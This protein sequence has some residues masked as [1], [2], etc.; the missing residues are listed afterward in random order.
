MM[1]RWFAFIPLIVF[2][3]MAA[4]FGLGLREDPSQIPSQLINEPLPAFDL[5]P[6]E[7][8]AAGLSNA[9]LAGHVS[10]LNVFGS[11]CPPCEVEHPMLMQIARSNIVPIYGVDWRDT[12]QAGAAWL[13]RHGNPY[14]AVGLDPDSHL[15]IDLGISGAPESFLIDASGRVR[16]RHVGIINEADWTNTILPLIRELEAS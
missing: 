2:G 10:L 5:A 4:Y 9:D 13:A 3:V 7:G 16:Y 1:G 11:W 8:A 15:A 12:P 6:V 14:S